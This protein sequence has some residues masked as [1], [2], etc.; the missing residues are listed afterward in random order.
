VL[1]KTYE[2]EV[3]SMARA[4]EIVGER[5][6]L[7]IIRDAL[8]AHVTRF[9]DFQRGLGV[10]PNVLAA[11]LDAF[12]TAGMMERR[13][14]SEQPE[15]FEYVLTAKGRDLAPAI[16]ALTRWGDRWAAVAEPPIVYT[17][18]DCGGAVEPQTA[19]ERCGA[20][21]HHE[22]QARPGPGMPAGYVEN[23][24]RGRSG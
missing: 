13:R 19:C 20:V 18:A 1:G 10:A 16:I 22:V 14:Y 12:V 8:F 23:R 21:D 17:H 7:L 24:R 3:C 2:R 11:R 5:W 15:Q 4:L 9:S 6:S